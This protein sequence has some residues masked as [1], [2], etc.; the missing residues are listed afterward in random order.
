MEKFED[1]VFINDVQF[2]VTGLYT[3]GRKAPLAYSHDDPKFDDTGDPTEIEELNIF[4]G[5]QE[6]TEVISDEVKSKIYEELLQ[7]LD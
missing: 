6:V 3:A 5:S 7:I 1:C 2:N 4:I